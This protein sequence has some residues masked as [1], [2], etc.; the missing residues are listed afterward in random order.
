MKLSM[1]V[2]ILSVDLE[3][4]VFYL[5]AS[6]SESD[7]SCPDQWNLDTSQ[8]TGVEKSCSYVFSDK[9]I[10]INFMLAKSVEGSLEKL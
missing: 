10:L 6:K 3:N 5:N 4:G 1:V 2:S 7:Q 9:I 8:C